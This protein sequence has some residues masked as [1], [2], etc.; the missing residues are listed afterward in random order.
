M[1]EPVSNRVSNRNW[2]KPVAIVI[3]VVAVVAA[4]GYG[5][6]SPWLVLNR[7]KT[8]ADTGDAA[9]LSTYV[10][11]PA[12]RASL[13]E[14]LDQL[15]KRRIGAEHSSNPLLLFGAAIGQALI[16]PVVD[17]Y[18]T[19]DGVAALL[20]GIPPTGK[21]GEAPPPATQNEEAPSP[22]NPPVQPE[23]PAPASENAASRP[24]STASYRGINEFAVTWQQSENSERYAAILRRHGLFSWRLAAV[25]LNGPANGAAP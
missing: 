13:K 21:P 7:M 25:E 20:N 23:A 16:G 6:A 3:I 11:Y 15:L 8:A 9:T 18:T 12:L 24:R 4:L 1:T 10:D 19:P 14:Q 5:Y 17:A 22:A 2:L